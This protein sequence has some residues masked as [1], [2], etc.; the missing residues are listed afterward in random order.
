VVQTFHLCCHNLMHLK[1]QC[2]MLVS[3][4]AL[5]VLMDA[6]WRFVICC[7]SDCVLS[8]GDVGVRLS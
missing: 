1:R 3:I 4:K 7:S 6:F 5:C 2:D 8:L